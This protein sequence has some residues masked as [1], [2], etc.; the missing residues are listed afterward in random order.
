MCNLTNLSIHE[1]H[2]VEGAWWGTEL[3]DDRK[4]PKLYC[5]PSSFYLH[6]IAYRYI[7]PLATIHSLQYLDSFFYLKIQDW[8]M[9]PRK[10]IAQHCDHIK[11][12]WKLKQE[13]RFLNQMLILIETHSNL[14]PSTSQ[15]FSTRQPISKFYY[16]W[17]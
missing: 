5:L 14:S 8:K 1:L 15:I 3:D 7:R 13:Y 4:L 11:N 16:K 17:I 6:M 10:S 9:F 12:R 2:S